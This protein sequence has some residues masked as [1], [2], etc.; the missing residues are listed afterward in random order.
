MP[1]HPIELNGT[2]YTLELDIEQFEQLEELLTPPAFAGPAGQQLSYKQIIARAML[3]QARYFTRVIWV[4]L[5]THHPDMK[6][7]D[8]RALIQSVGGIDAFDQLVGRLA[9]D[10]TP[11]PQDLKALGIPENPPKAQT[12]KRRM[13]ARST[14][15]RST[16]VPA[17]SV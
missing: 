2:I 13:N 1:K 9:T 12:R 17:A 15:D 7:E 6:L 5:R 14:G 16:S 4:A 11:D 3:G 8:V 10:A